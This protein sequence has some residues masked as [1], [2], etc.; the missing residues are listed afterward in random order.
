SPAS[1]RDSPSGEHLVRITGMT[2]KE[3]GRSVVRAM[4][5]PRLVRRAIASATSR[6]LVPAAVW[7]RLPVWGGLE[8]EVPGGSSI[9]YAAE[10]SDHAARQL[11]WVGPRCPELATVGVVAR[12]ARGARWVLDGGAN[13]GLYTL[14]A[15][16]AEP[17][18]RVIA[19]E[20]VPHNRK[21]LA[22]HLALN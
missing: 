17:G 10:P 16:A 2:W 15:C 19:F 18:C 8:I 20:P 4:T 3:R 1:P 12:F 6:G 7:R 5:R 9:T 22:E 13:V 21:G 14:V 11:H